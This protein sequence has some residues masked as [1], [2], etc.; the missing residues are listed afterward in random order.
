V[1]LVTIQLEVRERLGELEADFF[2]DDEVD[3]AINEAVK[4]FSSEEQWPWLYT[5]WASTL[6][7]EDNS[8]ELPESVSIG[9]IFNMS[10]S[11]GSLSRPRMLE[12]L[13][14]SAGFRAL[15][16]FDQ[17]S[18]APMYYYIAMSNQ[19]DN[20]SSPVQY[21]ARVVPTPDVAYDV[22]AQYLAIP[23]T[24][25][26]DT[27]EPMMP[28]EYQEAVPAWAA[29]KLF[30]KEMSISQKAQE[31]F[32]LYAKVLNQAREDVLSLQQDEEVAW[33][34]MAPVR[35]WRGNIGYDYVMGR[36]SP[37]GLGP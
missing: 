4:R 36:V 17:R 3:R 30:L 15:H 13:E 29:G 10:V 18:A 20:Q 2:S 14:P 16:A 19:D 27:D 28:E 35:R 6:I 37:S 12:R 23:A 34:R 11:G 21:T 22:Q 33:G 8:L 25:V 26:D 7:A 31:Q 5:E 1:E 24:L 32:G 9:R